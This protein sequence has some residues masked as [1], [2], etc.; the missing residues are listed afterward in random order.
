MKRRF[1][2]Q[3]TEELPGMNPTESGP[4]RNQKFSVDKKL[5]DVIR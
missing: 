4:D 1:G 3:K 2:G 5:L